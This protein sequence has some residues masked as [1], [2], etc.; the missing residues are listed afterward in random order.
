[1]KVALPQ[2]V[3]GGNAV[4][5]LESSHTITV[6]SSAQ[7]AE[8]VLPVA[9]ASARLGPVSLRR[10]FSLCDLQSSHLLLALV[11]EDGTVSFSRLHSGLHP[12]CF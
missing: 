6:W 9:A 1:M 12:P 3:G 5:Q 7:A 8:A 2:L 4:L 11:A 10:A